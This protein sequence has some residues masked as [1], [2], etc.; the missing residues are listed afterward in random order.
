MSSLTAQFGSVEVSLDVQRLKEGDRRITQEI[1]R[2]LQLFFSGTPWDEEYSDL[3][4]PVF[5]QMVF[6]S[7][8]EKGG[9][10]VYSA[11]C[12]FSNRLDQRYLARVIQFP[13]SSGQGILYSPVIFEPLASAMEFYALILLAGEADTYEPLGGTRFYER[14][15]ELALRGVQS[16]YPRGWSDRAELVDQLVKNRGLRLAKFYFYE[17]QALIQ[18]GEI[19]LAEESLDR[20]VDHLSQALTTLPREHYTMIFLDAHAKELSLLPLSVRNRE[21][22]LSRLIR[23][24]PDRKEIYETGLMAKSE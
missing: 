6:E 1:P 24:D 18:D 13:Y 7:V 12:L 21:K 16:L 23:L 3:Q 9:E 8:S 15:R 11:Q 20:M 4:I 17:V 2:Q 19:G 5:I 10:R 22:T 14:T